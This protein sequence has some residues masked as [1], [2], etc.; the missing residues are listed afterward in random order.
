MGETLQ[1]ALQAGALGVLGV[2][3]YLLVQAGRD[4]SRAA[5][6]LIAAHMR[7]QEDLGKTLVAVQSELERMGDRISHLAV[8][9]RGLKDRGVCP[10]LVAHDEKE[11][12]IR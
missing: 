12:R 10:M 4:A 6:P 3:L 2:L 8:E 11:G 1:I 5:L 7:T 9:V